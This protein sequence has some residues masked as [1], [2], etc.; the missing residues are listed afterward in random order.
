MNKLTVSI[1][2]KHTLW[3]KA[4]INILYFFVWIKIIK[5]EFALNLFCKTASKGFKIKIENG[6]WQPINKEISW[7]W[8]E[9][10]G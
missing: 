10:G 8:D 5:I 9:G 7:S 2:V 1:N 6:K 4:W 3:H